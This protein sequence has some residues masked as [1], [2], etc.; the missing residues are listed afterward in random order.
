MNDRMDPATFHARHVFRTEAEFQ[1]SVVKEAE[2]RGWWTYHT[3][4]SKGSQKGYPD[5]HCLRAERSFYAELKLEKGK[6]SEDQV[7]VIGK[8][9]DAGHV[10][11]VW[12]PS[13]WQEIEEVL[14]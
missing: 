1:A 14:S 9:R 12:K 3:L 13:S 11:Y 6:L 10:V 2:A 7:M 8:L 5:L 4:R